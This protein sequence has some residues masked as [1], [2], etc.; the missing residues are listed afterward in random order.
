MKI[1]VAI[2]TYNGAVY[3]REQLNSLE[4]QSRTV[5]EIVISDD[6]SSDETIKIA[7]DFCRESRINTVIVKNDGNVGYKRNFER[8]LLACG[9]DIIFLCDQ[10]DV[11]FKNKIEII[12]GEFSDNTGVFVVTNDQIITD[13]Q[14]NPIGIT[15]MEAVNR[16]A[17]ADSVMTGCCTAIRREFLEFSLPFPNDVASHDIWIG[18]L[19]RMLGVRLIHEEALQYWRR[20]DSN[21]SGFGV[22]DRGIGGIIK[23][24]RYALGVDIVE[25]VSGQI[26]LY[27]AIV[28]RLERENDPFLRSISVEVLETAKAKAVSNLYSLRARKA[29]LQSRGLRRM[30]GA[31]ELQASGGYRRFSGVRSMLLD[32]IRS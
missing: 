26:R 11:W 22:S 19:S 17:S 6:R 20:H 3:L 15:K 27:E 29:V 4:N 16:Y 23:H 10:D 21:V 24:A 5:D 8:A 12:V 32:M 28:G 1:S 14:L 9:G 25:R 7:E 30:L 13:R 31:I 18:M 2:A